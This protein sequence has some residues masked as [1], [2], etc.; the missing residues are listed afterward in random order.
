MSFGLVPTVLEKA[1]LKYDGGRTGAITRSQMREIVR[2]L[3]KEDPHLFN[4][5]E[6]ND[7]INKYSKGE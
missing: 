3:L 2:L 1:I 5:D 6:L 7:C 4:E